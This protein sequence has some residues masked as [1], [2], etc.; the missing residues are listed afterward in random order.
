MSPVTSITRKLTL[1]SIK[2]CTKSMGELLEATLEIERPTARRDLRFSEV[3]GPINKD[4]AKEQQRAAKHETALKEYY[5]A[6]Q[7]EIEKD[8]K[9][10]VQLSN[11]EIGCRLGGKKLVTLAKWT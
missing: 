6:N 2:D 7:K 9:K 4:I 5:V 3:C 10:F 1:N 11:G 8:G